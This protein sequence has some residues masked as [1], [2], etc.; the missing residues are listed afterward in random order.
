MRMER[1]F[2]QARFPEYFRSWTNNGSFSM[3]DS[4]TLSEDNYYY[5]AR[6]RQAGTHLRAADPYIRENRSL[7]LAL[8]DGLTFFCFGLIQRLTGDIR[9]TWILAQ[10]V[11][12]LLWVPVLYAFMR[13][14]GAGANQALCVAVAFTLFADLT[15]SFFIDRH[16]ADLLKNTLQYMF[17]FLGS[18]HY[19]F[20]PTRITGP[21]FTH[22]ALFI[23]SLA[24][25]RADARKDWGSVAIAGLS[26]GL[27]AYVHFDVWLAFL[28][29]APLY[30]LWR[31]WS[32][33][34][35]AWRIGAVWLIAAALSLPLIL[36]QASGL[37]G[38][39]FLGVLWERRPD[40][41][42]LP[43][44]AGA[45]LAL[46]RIGRDGMALWC[47]CMLAA[48]FLASNAQ[49]L[50]GWSM[51]GQGH[52]FY[53]GNTFLALTLGRVAGGKKPTDSPAWLCLAG[54]MCLLALPRV[55]GYSALHYQIYGMRAAQEEA[56]SWL[57]KNTPRDSVVAALSPQTNLKIPV[58]THNKIAVSFLFPVVSDIAPAEN[59][60]RIIH[61][62]SL[63]GAGLED[64]LREGR[65]GSEDWGK[66]LWTGVLDTESQ[67][68]AGSFF[69]Y[70]CM[71]DRSK[72]LSLL[73]DTAS[74]APTAGYP[75]DYL[76]VGP[77]E[78]RLIPASGLPGRDKL[79]RV[80]AN[81][82]ITLYRFLRERGAT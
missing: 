47:A 44:L 12:V 71:L 29:A 74:S 51:G 3:V 62:L 35:I 25:V 1:R 49:V 63:F 38:R 72:I 14:L 46:W 5:A 70:F 56:F 6:I 37:G 48:M 22:L 36:S 34:A 66:H 17:W 73:R 41:R 59:A 11:F 10:F 79:Q 68:R 69:L 53:I 52:W 23:A 80:F 28:G 50:T 81:S 33:R 39:D 54:F 61:A 75:A 32:A 26:G 9:T 45:V 30:G 16:F 40:W 15:R 76:W 24:F 8:T 60:R 65:S 67:E 13:R 31:S 55:T 21:L 27:L 77:F 4:F 2:Y 18:Y 57:S 19:F 7:R 82:E 42:A 78:R 43:F 20:G 58:H 64:F